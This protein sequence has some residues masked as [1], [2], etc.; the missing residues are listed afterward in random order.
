MPVSGAVQDSLDLAQYLPEAYRPPPHSPSGRKR[1]TIPRLVTV[2]VRT[3]RTAAITSDPRLRPPQ[4]PRV[5]RICRVRGNEFDRSGSR[6]AD[7]GGA[8]ALREPTA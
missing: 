3:L 6:C 4:E 5:G 7:P 8:S 1:L 2:L